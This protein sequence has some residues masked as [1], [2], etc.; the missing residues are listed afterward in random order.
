MTAALAVSPSPAMAESV[1]RQ[2]ER[3]ANGKDQ[4]W[5]NERSCWGY[6]PALVPRVSVDSTHGLDAAGVSIVNDF[7]NTGAPSGGV[8]VE[9][10]SAGGHGAL[11]AAFTAAGS[12]YYTPG[13][14]GGSAGNVT[15]IQRGDLYGAGSQTIDIALLRVYSMGGD[16]RVGYWSSGAGGAAGSVILDVQGVVSTSGDH[17]GGVWATSAGGQTGR[18]RSPEAIRAIGAWPVGI[19]ARDAYLFPGAAGGSV[20]VTIG[21][22]ARVS[23]KGGWAPGVIAESVG[24]AGMDGGTYQRVLPGAGNG[25][26]VTFSNH[27]AITTQGEAS[28]GVL[29]QSVGGRGGRQLAMVSGNVGSG[30]GK[31]GDAAHGGAVNVLQAGEITTFG[32]YSFGLAAWSI[33]GSG[34]NGASAWGGRSGG[35]GGAAGNG[36]SVEVVNSGSVVTHG[37]GAI[38]VVAQSLGGGGAVNAFQRS[39]YTPGASSGGGAGGGSSNAFFPAGKGG[40]GGSG[41]SGGAV[42]LAQN[43]MISTEG[44]SAFGVLAQSVGGGGGGGGSSSSVLNI[45][46]GYSAGGDG[47]GGGSG[48]FVNVTSTL[49]PGGLAAPSIT[50]TGRLASGIVAQSVGGGG[51]AGGSA[52]TSTAGVFAAVSVAIGGNG[53]MGGDG[54]AVFVEN[55][56]NIT[57]KG[58]EAHGVE[59]RSVGGGGG[60]AGNASAYAFAIA[61]PPYPALALSFAMGGD[62]GAGGAGGDVSVYNRAGVETWG[63]KAYGVYAGSI[64]GGGGAAGAAAAVADVIGFTKNFS[65]AFSLGGSAKGGGSGGLASIANVNAITT[66]GRFATGI[67]AQSIG[68][69]GGDGGAGSASAAKGVSNQ[70]YVSTIVQDGVPIADTWSVR[71]AIGGSGGRGGSGGLTLV[72]N[73]GSV[74]THGENARGILAQSIGGGG[75]SGGGFLS[76]GTSER[77]SSLN[78]GGSGGSGGNGGVVNVVNARSGRI[79]THDGGSAGIF[80]Q[81]VGGGGGDGGAL[82]AKAKSGPSLGSGIEATDAVLQLADDLIKINKRASGQFGNPDIARA[83]AGLLDKKS[84]TQERLGQAKTVL[85]IVKSGWSSAKDA[86]RQNEKI[87]K[88]N[89]INLKEGKPLIP[90]VPVRDFVSVA[91]YEAAKTGALNY[92]MEKLTDGLKGALKEVVG[93]VTPTKATVALN[94]SIGGS[95]GDGGAGG[96]VNVRNDGTIITHGPV[97]YGMFA[98]SVGGGGGSGGGAVTSGANWYN[99]QMNVGGSGGSGGSGGGVTVNN[100]GL[101]ETRGVASFGVLAQSIG[102]GGGL[103]GG[104]VNTDAIGTVSATVNMGGS[105]SSWSDGKDVV[106]TNSGT[107]RTQG[108]EAHG[109][110]AQSVGGGG[111]AYFVERKSPLSV[112][113]IAGSQEEL[114]VLR[115]ANDLLKD[116]NLGT[117]GQ[118]GGGKAEMDW[119]SVIPPLSLTASIGGRGGRGGDGG[120]VRVHQFGT[121]ETTGHGAIGLFAQSIG[122]GGG[123]GADA[124]AGGHATRNAVLGASGGA[125]GKG[126]D[127]NITFGGHANITTTGDG[128][129]GVFAQSIGGGGGYAGSGNGGWSV[130]NPQVGYKRVFEEIL[131]PDSLFSPRQSVDGGTVAIDMLDNAA[132]LSIHTTGASAHGVFVQSLGG[133][134]GYGY[135]I[136]QWSEPRAS[137]AATRFPFGV[138]EFGDRTDAPWKVYGKHAER[139]E[140]RGGHISIQTVGDIVATGRNA[141]GIFVQNGVQKADGSID[142][143]RSRPEHYNLIRH[144]GVIQGGSANGAAIRVDGGRTTVILEAGSQVSALSGQAILGYGAP[145]SISN[146]GRLTGGVDIADDGGGSRFV[147]EAGAVFDTGGGRAMVFGYGEGLL[148]RVNLGADGAFINRGALEVGGVGTLG[149][150]WFSDQTKVNLGGVMNVDVDRPAGSNVVSADYIQASQVHIDGLRIQPRVGERLTKTPLSVIEAQW[151]TGRSSASLA[152]PQAGPVSWSFLDS[153]NRLII[154]PKADFQGATGGAPL[155]QTELAMIMALQKG[156]D[157][158]SHPEAMAQS[159]IFAALANAGS[160]TEYMNAIDRLSPEGRQQPAAAQ[161]VSARGSMGRALSCPVFVDGGA[162]INENQCVWGAVTGGRTMLFNTSTTDGYRQDSLSYQV[163]GQWELAPNW[164]LGASAAYNVDMMQSSDM[165]TKYRGQ[166]GDVSVALKHQVGAWYFAAVLHAGFASQDVRTSFA[167]DDEQWMNK[168]DTHAWTFG[169]RGRAAYE[170]AFDGWYLRPYLDVDVIHTRMPGYVTEGV[171]ATMKIAPLREWTVAVSPAVELGV[172][173]D[174]EPGSWLRPYVSLGATWLSDTGLSTRA[175]FVDG[176]SEGPGFTSTSELPRYLLDVG[177]GVQFFRKGGFELRGE[178]KAQIGK[179]YLSH[180]A[181]VRAAIHF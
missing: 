161:T 159:Q 122:G 56:S 39:S 77:S 58:M 81:S 15:V 101:I 89:E 140:G 168:V 30:G 97:S 61:P 103:A 166:G 98:Q 80:A 49:P 160:A 154:Q 45:L 1:A 18:N 65:L 26:T 171:G 21:P 59:A 52:N 170:F 105:G 79:E 100:G 28:T 118:T 99:I 119:N 136:N 94:L 148:S 23:T 9:I 172:R 155:T 51:G 72:S 40:E 17:F 3:G 156:W 129:M 107:I 158:A 10:G 93:K 62:G 43:G 91:I 175:S 34:G 162:M 44:E 173:A 82:A 152:Q 22:A 36:G 113:N 117:L 86:I 46:L 66:H 135:N 149:K 8:A 12:P 134:G 181:G 29:A 67:L 71:L 7:S 157:S 25:G 35:D 32:N 74:T 92:I 60:K 16:G 78:I 95:G 153:G 54:G 75:G 141:Y 115:L 14:K 11:G 5:S 127:I 124:G 108:K 111:G 106:V 37:K 42:L 138:S 121:I 85:T 126:G 131:L 63:E 68:G 64:G 178:Y 150:A 4:C 41:G 114:E 70:G 142:I 47:G 96:A 109:L 19:D 24:G 167:I 125:R 20:A 133:G 179:D 33:G 128:A 151:L 50:T 57:T 177:A 6:N 13:K 48:G 31:G 76:L 83:E 27:G 90:E 116:F 2:V 55:G 120:A 139:E 176:F 53:G 165:A 180:R 145:M 38:G 147:N 73:E 110:V 104:A 137:N 112:D 84:P 146:R 144:T 132:R 174:L 169:A 87:R 130:R 163:G 143:E 123:F 69:G 164:F 88:Q 102:G